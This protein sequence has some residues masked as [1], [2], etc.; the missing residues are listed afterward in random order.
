MND[1]VYIIIIAVL[2]CILLFLF[3]YANEHIRQI[4]EDKAKLE[5]K[6]YERKQ[7]VAQTYINSN[8]ELID[9][10]KNKIKETEELFE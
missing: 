2:L 8:K 10:I 5:K 4:N 6:Y 9:D 1:V 3:P 7:K